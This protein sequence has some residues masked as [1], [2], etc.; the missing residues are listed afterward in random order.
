[1]NQLVGRQ[2]LVSLQLKYERDAKTLLELVRVI[3]GGGT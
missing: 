2:Y 1:M 3:A